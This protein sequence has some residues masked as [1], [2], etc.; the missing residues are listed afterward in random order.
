MKKIPIIISVVMIVIASLGEIADSYYNYTYYTWDTGKIWSAI[1]AAIFGLSSVFA[2]HVWSWGVANKIKGL[3]G[4]PWYLNYP[5]FAWIVFLI[6]Y[7]GGMNTAV[8]TRERVKKEHKEIIFDIPAPDSTLYFVALEQINYTK[9]VLNPKRL[10]RIGYAYSLDPLIDSLKIEAAKLN[11]YW[12]NAKSELK[13]VQSA[14][15]KIDDPLWNFLSGCTGYLLASLPFITGLISLSADVGVYKL[16]EA[17]VKKNMQFIEE[18]AS[19]N[20]GLTY[21]IIAEELGVSE[22]SARRFVQRYKQEA[23]VNRGREIIRWNRKNI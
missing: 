8:K 13:A 6:V 1:I 15:K 19:G 12:M 17:N 14:D 7:S 16:A 22:T 2:S 5:I 21:K 4:L 3:G 9:N 20:D 18:K 23:I 11:G 10:E